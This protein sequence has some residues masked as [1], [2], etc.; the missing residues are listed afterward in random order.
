MILADKQ[1]VNVK[2]LQNQGSSNNSRKKTRP[3]NSPLEDKTVTFVDG[4]GR[5]W[6]AEMN[7]PQNTSMEVM[8]SIAQANIGMMGNKPKAKT[9]LVV[10]IEPHHLEE[11]T[12]GDVERVV[13]FDR[14]KLDKLIGG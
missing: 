14:S 9:D 2:D 12:L 11:V 13:I 10:L 8:R 5:M 6:T 4:K 7:L 3:N 1:K